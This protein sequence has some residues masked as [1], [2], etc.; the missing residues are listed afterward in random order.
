MK[1]EDTDKSE[2]AVIKPARRR[3]DVAA[4]LSFLGPGVGQ[5]LN[6]DLKRAALW[7]PA[8]PLLIFISSPMRIRATFVG[9]VIYHSIQLFISVL[10]A[11]DA[12]RSA[13][14]RAGTNGI[15]WRRRVGIAALAATLIAAMDYAAIS[16]ATIRFYKVPVISMAPTIAG[17]ERVAV[18]LHYYAHRS[19]QRGDVVV[20]GSRGDTVM[21]KRIAALG[22]DVIEGK[23]GRVFVNG[24]PFADRF[25]VDMRE[26]GSTMQRIS[27]FGPQLIPPGKFFV[28]G[29]NRKHSWDSRSPDFGLVDR[30][31]IKGKVLYVY[32]SSKVSQ[33]GRRVE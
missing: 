26:L 27:Q 5:A 9:F 21:V 15:T 10:S 29:D 32:W 12:F 20:M 25:Q 17:G 6:G 14:K 30:T 4:V 13:V 33:I 19:P 7:G 8:I 11:R 31:D 22:G 18:D 16:S 3:A 1:V 23:E 24:S 28:L 2:N